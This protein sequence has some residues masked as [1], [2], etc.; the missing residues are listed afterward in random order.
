MKHVNLSQI[1]NNELLAP[2]PRIHNGR[3]WD[4]TMG[5]GDGVAGA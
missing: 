2:L 1:Q 5:A 4:T 3:T